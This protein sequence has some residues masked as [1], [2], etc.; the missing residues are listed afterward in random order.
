MINLLPPSAKKLVSREFQLRT[1]SVSM[2]VLAS[3][4]SVLAILM[5]PTNFLIFTLA[6]NLSSHLDAAKAA[7]ESYGAMVQNVEET[8]ALIAYLEA[9][10][11]TEF[12]KLLQELDTAAGNS[13][14]LTEF[15][16]DEAGKKVVISGLADTRSNLANFRT[17][18]ESKEKFTAVELPLSNLA[19][20]TDI[21]F[22]MTI[23]L[24]PEAL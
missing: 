7:A 22:T 16:F 1:V 4:I 21:S 24:K 18:L 19:K 12:S 15:S 20:D 17:T 5:I 2:L 3:L 8:N 6:S 10:D 14:Y 9:D 11:R 13:I 23:T